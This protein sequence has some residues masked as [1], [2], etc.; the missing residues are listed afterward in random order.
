MWG[1]LL[2]L[3]L[4][5]PHTDI[6][7]RKY[8]SNI[9]TPMS[10]RDSK[11]R[12]YTVNGHNLQHRRYLKQ[13]LIKRKKLFKRVDLAWL[14]SRIPFW[15]FP[16]KN[17]RK[18]SNLLRENTFIRKCCCKLSPCCKLLLFTVCDKSKPFSKRESVALLLGN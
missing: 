2:W 9:S 12:T 18:R 10:D 14:T 8:E 15:T 3:K 17:G 4:Q 16:E 6:I 7:S 11:L 5:T 1:M 13:H